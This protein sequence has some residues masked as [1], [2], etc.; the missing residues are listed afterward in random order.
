MTETDEGLEPY[1]PKV[2]V[3]FLTGKRP[4]EHGVRALWTYNGILE[5]IRYL[6]VISWIKGKRRI[7]KKLGIKPKL[8]NRSDYRFPT[9]F[10]LIPNSK[11]INFIGYNYLTEMRERL[12]RIFGDRIFRAKGYIE[13]CWEGC[14]KTYNLMFRE[15]S[16]D[17]NLFAVYFDIL[18]WLGH[19]YINKSV[20]NLLIPYQVFDSLVCEIKETVGDDI[21]FLILSDHG[22]DKQ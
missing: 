15:I 10:E 3:S 18:D 8:V 1:T 21:I 6:P 17:W 14:W 12:Q 7:L 16:S 20:R 11:A 22:R 13:L 19:L 4:R 2:W 9:L 5:K